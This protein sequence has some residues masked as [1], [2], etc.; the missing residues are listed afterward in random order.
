MQKN[1]GDVP[2]CGDMNIKYRTW[3]FIQ[4]NKWLTFGWSVSAAIFMTQLKIVLLISAQAFNMYLYRDKYVAYTSAFIAKMIFQ[5]PSLVGPQQIHKREN[6]HELS[7][8]YTQENTDTI[9]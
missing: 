4:K 3:T 8:E 5:I 7:S 1:D 6:K 2:L 9:M